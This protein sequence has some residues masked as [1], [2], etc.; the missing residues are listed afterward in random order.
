MGN[1]AELQQQNDGVQFDEGPAVEEVVEKAPQEAEAVESTE[2][3][4]A[5]AEE[6]EKVSFTPEQ[7]AV[8]DKAIGDK[9]RKMREAE[10]QKEQIAAEL[11]RTRQLVPKDQRPNVPAMPDPYDDDYA[12]RVAE[13]DKAIADAA[14][15]DAKQAVSEQQRIEREQQ[16]QFQ[17]QQGF[18]NTVQEYAKRATTLGVTQQEL[19]ESG[20]AVKEYGISDDVAMHILADDKGPLITKYLAR[21]PVELDNIAQMSPMRAAAYIESVVKP[22]IAVPNRTTNAPAP[23]ETLGRR[24]APRDDGGLPGVKYE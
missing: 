9:V 14:A 10:R 7:Q 6:H 20:N 4:S 21:N 24:G 13:R 5:P 1:E 2:A 16:R 22:K 3:E 8:F 12:R 15:W 17:A 18:L 23:P 11:E 19:A